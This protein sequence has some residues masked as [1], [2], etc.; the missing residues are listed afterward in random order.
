VHSGS[1][2]FFFRPK[3][4]ASVAQN[5]MA[6][7]ATRVQVNKRVIDESSKGVMAAQSV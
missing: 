6:T 7:I 1:A 4:C 5:E 2:F 3:A